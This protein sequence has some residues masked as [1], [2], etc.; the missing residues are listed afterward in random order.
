[1]R[2]ELKN[3]GYNVRVVW[4][5]AKPWVYPEGRYF[6][7]T[8]KQRVNMT[9]IYKGKFDITITGAARK[10][11]TEKEIESSWKKIKAE[12]KRSGKVQT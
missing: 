11:L 2:T 9:T 12:E 3:K 8:K 5:G 4:S 1:M 7:Y 10:P 6:V